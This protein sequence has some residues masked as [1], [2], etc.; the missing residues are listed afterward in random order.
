MLNFDPSNVNAIAEFVLNLDSNRQSAILGEINLVG[1][2]PVTL[3]TDEQA[4]RAYDQHVQGGLGACGNFMGEVSFEGKDTEGKPYVETV[5]VPI[6]WG[7]R[8]RR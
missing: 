1:I 5:Q 7:Q 3:F 4:R 2:G 6:V 8:P